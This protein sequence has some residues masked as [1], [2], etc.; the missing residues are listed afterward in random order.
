M[1]SAVGILA[2]S[3]EGISVMK[4]EATIVTLGLYTPATVVYECANA[5]DPGLGHGGSENR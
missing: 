2:A 4:Y 3:C 1:A 5:A